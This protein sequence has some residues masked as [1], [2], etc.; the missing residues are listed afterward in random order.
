MKI[1]VL[2]VGDDGVCEL[3]LDEEAKNYL[4][5]RGFNDMLRQALRLMEKE[6]EGSVVQLDRTTDF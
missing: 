5:E 1:D 6:K 4:I 3:E 2:K